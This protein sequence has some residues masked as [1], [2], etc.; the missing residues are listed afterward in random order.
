[1]NLYNFK[2][3]IFWEEISAE[4]CWR[5]VCRNSMPGPFPKPDQVCYFSYH[6]W[7]SSCINFRELD[8]PQFVIV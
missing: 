8:I 6:L 2:V 4:I 1:M 3:P 7:V 5:N